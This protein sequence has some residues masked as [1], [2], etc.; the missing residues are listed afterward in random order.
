MTLYD[1]PSAT[2]LLDAVCAF[3]RDDVMTGGSSVTSFHGRVAINVLE[4]VAREISLGPATYRHFQDGLAGLGAET[5]REL[6]EAIRD[7]SQSVDD[8]LLRFV[9]T[10]THNRLLVSNPAYLVQ[11]TDD[12]PRNAI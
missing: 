3:L 2:D 8:E 1:N 9:W 5:E 11:V 4:Q 10:V 12:D 7:G 6:S